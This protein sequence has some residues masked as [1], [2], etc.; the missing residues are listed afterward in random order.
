[1]KNSKR[2]MLTTLVVATFAL[3]ACA[4]LFPGH[5]GGGHVGKGAVAVKVR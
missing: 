4:P 2:V 5:H 1:M 3:S